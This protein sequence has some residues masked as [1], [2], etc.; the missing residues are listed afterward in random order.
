MR[1]QFRTAVRIYAQPDEQQL[2]TYYDQV[3][4]EYTSAQRHY[5]SL[6]HI[7]HMLDMAS[8]LQ[9]WVSAPGLVTLAIW[10][11]DAVYNPLSAN[12]EAD[13]AALAS[14]Q[15]EILGLPR[16]AIDRV[17]AMI[18]A[19]RSH[20]PHQT[21]EDA[22]TRLLLD[23]D[24][25]VLGQP[26]HVYQQYV[27]HVRKEYAMVDQLLFNEGRIRF[28]EH[29]LA[30]AQLYRLPQ[31]QQHLESAARENMLHELVER[32]THGCYPGEAV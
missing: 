6:A 14:Q 32:R 31:V 10:Y 29:A 20:L 27:A 1:S 24:L 3:L 7:A 21:D 22:E 13:S 12:N 17:A 2:Q 25:A 5:H 4:A 23:C 18:L 19:T 11:H 28:L 16:L 15:L 8:Q 9:H 26:R 30:S